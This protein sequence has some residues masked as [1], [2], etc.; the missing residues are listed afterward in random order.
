MAAWREKVPFRET[1]SGFG[2]ITPA[3]G[4]R[5]EDKVFE[6]AAQAV[7]IDISTKFLLVL[8]RVQDGQLTDE[9]VGGEIEP[10]A[11]FFEVPELTSGKYSLVNVS[12][13]A[14]RNVVL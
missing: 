4:L 3:R 5:G 8:Q 12:R 10:K 11:C 13:N 6:L 7:T 9:R 14:D 2:Q 1:S